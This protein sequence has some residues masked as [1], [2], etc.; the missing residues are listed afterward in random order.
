MATKLRSEIYR[1]GIQSDIE[2]IPHDDNYQAIKNK[3]NEL[4]D[5]ID[6]LGA[7]AS[8]AEVT[9][10]RPYHTN[11]KNRLDSIGLDQPSYLKTGGAVTESSPAAMTV[12]VAAGQAKVYGV[13]VNWSA[14]TLGPIT[15]PS[16]GNNRFDIALINSDNTLQI[17]TG[18][19]A[20][21]PVYPTIAST[22]KPLAIIYLTDSH[23]TITN[24][25]I[26]DARDQG[27]TYWAT[28]GV[29]WSWLIQD[30]VNN[31]T[32]GRIR[33]GAGTYYEEVDL[34]GKSNLIIDFDQ[35]AIVRR[36]LSTKYAI[37]AI[38]TVGN[39][40]DHITI[41][42][43]QFQGN[44]L[45]GSNELMRIEYLDKFVIENC[46]FDGNTSSTATYKNLF[47][48]NCDGFT[49]NNALFYD[50]S[51]N[52]SDV[53]YFFDNSTEYNL[54][55]SSRLIAG[56]EDQFDFVRIFLDGQV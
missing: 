23:V 43:G 54:I 37:K 22:Q 1:I 2:S 29:R 27:C 52:I 9:Q 5:E 4:I 32:G 8:I 25:D 41:K 10:A 19:E 15:A 20:A 36:Y 6:A 50:G 38:N 24:S 48:D 26:T 3:I 28:G 40:E 47:I 53:T 30:A 39:E 51:G 55:T 13:D 17:A 16:A 18:A 56:G 45:A 42:G 44:S 33:V 14:A 11:L 49:I 35:G 31:V 12:E 46:E 34:S 21:N 7:A